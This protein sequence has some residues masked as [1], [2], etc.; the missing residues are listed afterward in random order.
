MMRIPN[1]PDYVEG[2]I[3]LRGQVT[4]VI[5]RRKRLGFPD[6]DKE[7]ESG[8]KIIVVEYEEVSIGMVVERRKRRKIP[9]F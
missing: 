2:V 9:F 6:K 5:N 4:T 3:N 8:E 1:A 7:R